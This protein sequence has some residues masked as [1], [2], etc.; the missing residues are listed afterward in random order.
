[1]DKNC[2]LFLLDAYALIYRAYF[3]FSKNPRINSKGFNTSAVMGFVNT[4]EDILKKEDPTHIGVV[5][6]PPGGSFRHEIYKEYKAQREE[7]PETIR[8]SVPIIKDILAAYRIP[9]IEVKGY[10]ADDVIGTLSLQAGRENILTYMMTPDK[11]YGQLVGGTVYMYR[12]KYGDKEYEIMG[13]E[14]IKA[15]FGITD[16]AQVIDMLGLMG[17]SSDNIPGCPGVGEK[18]A[19]KLIA[20]Y[21]SIENLLDN[22]DKLKGALKKKI[23][24]NKE[25]IKFSKFLA[26]IKT[27]VPIS[28]DMKSLERESPDLEKLR[29]IFEEM[30]FRTLIDR[31]I[32]KAPDNN[33]AKA[34]PQDNLLAL[35]A[36]EDTKEQIHENLARLEDLD[37]SY[38]LIET[39]KDMDDFLA[40]FM[41]RK[42]FSLDTET[43]GTDPITAKLVGMS[44]SC[45]ENEAFYIPVPQDDSKAKETVK[46]I[47]PLVENP[48]SLKVGQNMKYD[49]I[50]LAR[51]GAEVRGEMFDTMVAHYVIQPELRHNMDY[52]AEIYLNYR[53]IHIEELIGEKKKG[54]K[55][56]SDL[57]PQEI[58]KYACEDADVTLKLKNILEKE[59]Q[60][61]NDEKLF[62]EIEMPLVPVLAQMEMNG[63]RIDI[64][65]LKNIS[66]EL[67]AKM[68]AIETEIYALAGTE[69]NISSPRQVGDI[70][71]NR[72]QLIEK[73]KKT[74]SG[75]YSTSEEVL[76]SMRHKHPIVEKILD[77]RGLKKLL[78]TYVDALPQL[79]NPETGKIHTSFNQTVTATGRLSSSNPNLQNIPVRDENGREIRRAFIPDDGCLF[80]SADYSQIELRIMAHMSG[81]KGM[82]EAFRSGEDIHTDTAAKV[83][84]VPAAEVTKAMRSKAKTA[85]FGII[86]GIS[87]FGLA[88][89][90]GVDRREAKELIDEYFKTYPGIKAYIEKSVDDAKRNGYAE[91]LFHRKRFLP[92]I[93]SH[94]AVVRGYAERNAI[95]APIQGTAADIIKVAMINIHNR[96]KREG[97]KA[98]MII[99]V[100]D[101]LDFNVPENEKEQLQAIVMEEM[102]NACHMSVPLTADCGWGANWLEAH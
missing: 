102:Q 22:T 83:Y 17:D 6:D 37:Y 67:S 57:T 60:E 84:K 82:V 32:R 49:I 2:K 34:A 41:T 3:A 35:F 87:A 62:R 77:Y 46:K 31:I 76:E 43:T 63:A 45:K 1:M 86:Y 99:Q 96:L 10:E 18:T 88:E 29:T 51:Y 58:Y 71:F 70:L 53:T 101:E 73:A 78:T 55:K 23:E 7:T 74:K 15:K 12:P 95:N 9:A 69:F 91:T 50:M 19:Q 59:L 75:Q 81:D 27:D 90:M 20:E 97:L 92:D 52:L 30:E 68:Q 89:R 28:L 85:N 14:E 61:K 65:A 26:T 5:F 79:I 100:H 54:Q 66:E 38:K 47:K 56:M 94:N 24:E 11:D 42:V 72:L 80:F 40:Y 48:A 21:G 93:N 33:A 25:Q 39:E 4:L 98:Q 8:Q 36:D 44:F 13:T 16:T 64:A